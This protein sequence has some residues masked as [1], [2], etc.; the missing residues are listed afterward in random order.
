MHIFLPWST[1]L[2]FHEPPSN[3]HLPPDFTTHS[4]YSSTIVPSPLT[5]PTNVHFPSPLPPFLLTHAFLY[6]QPVHTHYLFHSS[7]TL[8]IFRLH[9][10][11]LPTYLVSKP[12]LF[13]TTSSLRYTPAT[14]INTYPLTHPPYTTSYLIVTPIVHYYHNLS[15]HFIYL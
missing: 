15:Q 3:F 6:L 11:T 8:P 9:T 12:F 1:Y 10:S 14:P 13:I 7:P 2:P 5:T 4:L